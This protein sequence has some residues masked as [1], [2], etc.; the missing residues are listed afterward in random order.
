MSDTGLIRSH[1]DKVRQVASNA[2]IFGGDFTSEMD[3]VIAEAIEH[4]S[5]VKTSDPV[6]NL[7]AFAGQLNVFN[8]V[9]TPGTPQ[10]QELMK[11]AASSFKRQIESR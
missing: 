2:A 5:I 4:I 1:I 6:E 11:Y 8:Q 7:Q 9:E 10:Y 3:K